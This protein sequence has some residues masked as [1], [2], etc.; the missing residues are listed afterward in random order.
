MLLEDQ[1]RHIRLETKE[2][3]PV[4]GAQFSLGAKCSLLPCRLPH[5]LCGKGGEER[6][7]GV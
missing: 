1:L 2:G 5:P 6:F 3:Q 4:D 7:E